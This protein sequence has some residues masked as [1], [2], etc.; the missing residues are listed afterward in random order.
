MPAN[1]LQQLLQYPEKFWAIPPTNRWASLCAELSRYQPPISEWVLQNRERKWELVSA[2]Q[3]A[4]RRGDKATALRLISGMEGMAE[5]WPY[6]WR[7]LCTTVCEDVGPADPELTRFVIACSIVTPKKG[8]EENYPLVCFLTEKMC[9]LEHRS[10]VYCSCSFVEEHLSSH[11]PTWSDRDEVVISWLNDVSAKVK[12]A[13]TPVEMW[14][15]T[16]NWRGEGMLKY[17]A[18]DLPFE[19]QRSSLPLPPPKVLFGL[20]SYAFDQHTRIGLAVL[21]RLVKG[22]AGA[23][24]IREFLRH[25]KVK[26]PHPA[27]GEA[28]F[29][30]EGS[31]IKG[32]LIC[33][34]L[35]SLEQRMLALQ[36]G[37]SLE[38]W[39]RLKRLVQNALEEGVI[40]RVR[41]EV[42]LQAHGQYEPDFATQGDVGGGQLGLTMLCRE[43]REDP[44]PHRNTEA[45]REEMFATFKHMGWKPDDLKDPKY[46]EQ[47]AAW[48]KKQ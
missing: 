33:E 27:V 40:D 6:F 30:V 19:M 12:S 23:E 39:E 21:R 31:R 44:E 16:N 32:E 35:C 42:L 11:L 15:S 36:F 24:E 26:N 37:L 18:K 38:S 25:Q 13:S 14:L 17:L 5:E 4:V 22:V 3:K 8:S 29:Y 9:D 20:P 45:Y 2:F 46:R 34:P 7:R 28:L 1:V 43:Y 47:Y 10:R 41:E 48:L